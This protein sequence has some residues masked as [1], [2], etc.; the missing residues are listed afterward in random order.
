MKELDN[1]YASF[2]EPAQGCFLALREI[3]LGTDVEVTEAW[4]YQLPFFC[5]KGKMF[6]YLWHDKK[7]NMP[8]VGFVEGKRLAHPLL[9]QEKRERMKIFLVDPLKDIDIENLTA[10][11]QEAIDIYRNG[12]VAIKGKK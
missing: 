12:I 10:I 11:L 8:Y 7:R 3:I 2:Q 4:K 1:F 5:Y 6:C 9:L